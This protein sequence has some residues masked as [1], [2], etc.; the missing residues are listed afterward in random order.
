MTALLRREGPWHDQPT[1]ASFA[2]LF[3]V[4]S[5]C[6]PARLSARMPAW[7]LV[8]QLVLLAGFS[9]RTSAEAS[10]PVAATSAIVNTS[11]STASTV[12]ALEASPAGLGLEPW[13]RY[14]CDGNT[15]RTFDELRDDDF[16]PLPRSHISLGFRPD[17]CWFRFRLENR[18]TLPQE[19]IFSVDYPVLDQVDIH[20]E[21]ATG[22][23]HLAL[24]DALPF[25]QRV[26]D[27][28]NF[29]LPFT[30]APGASETFT[31]R[32]QSTGSMT[33]PLRLS[34]RDSFITEL[35]I[36]EWWLGA[37]YGISL[38]LLFYHA[39]LWM[40]LREKIYRFFVLHV[41]ASLVYL[42]TLQGLAFRLWPNAPEW[43]T[44][45]NFLAGYVLMLSG[46]L[47]ARDYLNTREWRLGDRLLLGVASLLGMA[48]VVQAVLPL[49]LMYATLAITAAL[50]MLLLFLTGL[51]RWLQGLREARQFMLAWGLFLLMATV[52]SLK[53]SGLLASLPLLATVNLLQVGIILQQV[54]LSLGLA[55]RLSALKQEKIQKEQEVLRVQAENVAKGDFLAKMSHEI[56]TPMNAVIGLAELLRDSRLEPAQREQVNMMH[57]AGR[58]LLALINDILDYSRINAGK[59]ALE[60]TVFHLPS[61]LQE[62]VS[63]YAV[64]ASQ[65][66]LALAWEPPADL[67]D[68]VQADAGRLRQILGNL[69][70]NAIKFTHE[71]RIE[72]RTTLLPSGNGQPFLLEVEIEDSGIGLDAADIRDLFQAFHQADVSTSRQYGGSGLGLAISK[73]LVELM[74]G[75]IG[76]RSV[77]GEGSVFWFRIPLHAASAPEETRAPTPSTTMLQGRCVLVV[78][79]NAVNQV[80]ITG[81]LHKLGIQPLL[82]YDGES[83]LD[84]LRQHPEIELVLMDCEMPGMDGYE[85]TRRLREREA[86]EKRERLPV[87]ALTAHAMADHR[88]RCLAAGMDDHLAKP[89][90][91]DDLAARLRHYLSPH[92]PD[93][94]A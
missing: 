80:V 32:V 48:L 8:L 47:F 29:L 35:E 65:K 94:T 56:R 2:P 4:L 63:M 74:Q 62:C 42:A 90:S 20:R 52:F 51:V 66:S 11:A 28:R 10:V 7:L 75:E 67:P 93:P 43:N 36:R 19:L 9:G 3:A 34:G 81:F 15:P 91:L 44:R 59:L 53:A 22:I 14:H 82:A 17:A 77:R 38:G 55:G 78:E 61:L 60:S 23:Q 84:L 68:W 57:S 12:L 89:V 50:V 33:V 27:S 41:G 40:A 16:L 37:F 24:G 5:A 58:S 45:S 26:L 70:G 39:F 76:V 18:L 85:A 49:Q 46:V 25:T 71:G 83:G 73:Q 31:L 69:L 92:A 64:N 54:L 72:V 30:L 87:I 6:R 1:A 21:S 86:H 88:S 13:V 79:D